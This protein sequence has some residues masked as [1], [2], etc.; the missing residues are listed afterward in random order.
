MKLHPVLIAAALSVAL[1]TPAAAQSAA[2]PDG[3]VRL[4]GARVKLADD[5]D[6][7]LNGALDP[8]AGYETPDDWVVSG[9]VGYFV[10]DNVAVQFSATSPATTPNIPAGSLAGLPNLGTDE[11]SVFGLT[12][13]WH[14][15]RGGRVSPYVGA[16]VAYLHVWDIE[17][18]LAANLDI[19]DAFGPVVQAG[20]EV[21]IDERF[22]VFVEARQAFIETDASGDIGPL[23]VTAE[24]E[25][26]PF[27]L[28]A[29]ALFRF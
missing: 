5:G 24:P 28:Q 26:D 14:P 8:Q 16:G 9:D 29:G 25:L 19:Q 21:A 4:G 11:F 20:V 13:V 27:I 3:F 12:G 1:A 23:R 17:D 6:I 2:Q 7:F 10:L 18:G 15:L 22:G